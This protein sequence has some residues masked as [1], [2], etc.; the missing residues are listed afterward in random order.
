MTWLNYVDFSQVIEMEQHQKEE[1][2][3]SVAALNQLN[4]TNAANAN[5]P[6]EPEQTHRHSQPF[7]QP[8]TVASE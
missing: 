1:L 4:Q 3:K 5:P 7:I 8:P 2:E 6:P